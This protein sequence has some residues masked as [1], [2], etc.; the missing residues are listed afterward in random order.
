MVEPLNFGYI[1]DHEKR[2]YLIKMHYMSDDEH[3]MHSTFISKEGGYIKYEYLPHKRD[4]SVRFSW[5][6]LYEMRPYQQMEH[7]V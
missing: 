1:I 6:A 2:E 7:R 5:G 3:M 4:R